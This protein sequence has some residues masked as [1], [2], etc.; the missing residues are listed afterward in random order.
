MRIR[1]T[2]SHSSFSGQPDRDRAEA[3]RRKRRVGER[4]RGR[5]L[6][7]APSGL[8][9]V[10]VQGQALLARLEPLPG[11]DEILLFEITA[12]S[13]D[14]VLRRLD[15]ATDPAAGLDP[16]QAAGL[17]GCAR[18]LAEAR[19]RLETALGLG[20]DSPWPFPLPPL[21]TRRPTLDALLRDRPPAA[22]EAR[23]LA[24][25]LD[26]VNACLPPG[27]ILSCPLWLV[28][29][30]LGVE[31]LVRAGDPGRPREILLGFSPPGGGPALL[32]VTAAP[33]GV[34]YRV[35]LGPTPDQGPTPAATDLAALVRDLEA[36][37]GVVFPGRGPKPGM[38]VP[39]GTSRLSPGEP[40]GPLEILL[41]GKAG[42]LRLNRRV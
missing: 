7:P 27:N 28:P 23:N 18:T 19:T 41:R 22:T 35:L 2:G 25:V 14:I 33:G 26:R 36:L 6:G 3:F 30:G 29:G 40:A 20:P 8:A 15:L 39:L 37:P 34:G 5:V 9:W 24:A 11:P 21:E 17:A 32:R 12:L 38:G 10:D 1:D 13:P 16:A 4:V 31:L 42:G